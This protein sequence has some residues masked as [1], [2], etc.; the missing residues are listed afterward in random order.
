MPRLFLNEVI[1][2]FGGGHVLTWGGLPALR[3]SPDASAQCSSAR[4]DWAEVS[5]RH[6]SGY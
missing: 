2:A 1:R 5:R 4:S 6:S 3:L